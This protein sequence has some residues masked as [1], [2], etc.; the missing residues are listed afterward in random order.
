MPR[1]GRLPPA[2]WSGSLGP[3]SDPT[4]SREF[5]FRHSDGEALS[6]L[7]S[8]LKCSYAVTLMEHCCQGPSVSRRQPQAAPATPPPPRQTAAFPTASGAR[9]D[10]LSMVMSNP[11]VAGEPSVSRFAYMSL[12]PWPVLPSAW[13]GCSSQGEQWP[14]WLPWLRF[15]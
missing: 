9:A 12:G 4:P 8:I 5:H 10:D 6:S 2:S 7:S 13:R 11:T 3:A 14:G 1:W 15:L